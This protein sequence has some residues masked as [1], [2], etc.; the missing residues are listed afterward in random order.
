MKT[1][2]L[3]QEDIFQE[4]IDELQKTIVSQG[5]ECKFIKYAPFDKHQYF[6]DFYH[7]DDCVVFYGSLNLSR[8]IQRCTEWI[9]GSWCYLKKFECTYYYS[10]FGEFLLNNRYIMLPYGELIRQKEFLYE[11]LGNSE[12]LFVRP[13]SGFKSFTGTVIH[14]DEFDRKI[15]NFGAYDIE[16]HHVVVVSEPK[17]IWQEWRLFVVDKQVVTG[18]LYKESRKI[19]HSPNVPNEV[20]D[21]GNSI[22]NLWQPDPAF[23]LDVCRT[24]SGELKLVEINSFSSSGFYACDKNKLVKSISEMALKEWKEYKT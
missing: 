18:S 3:L 12:C 17:N 19:S 13:S 20:I 8:K 24:N 11:T 10:K 2:W 21:F 7:E 22:A 4:N 6:Y 5:M 23:A 16:D 14:I 15:E 9:P 1:K